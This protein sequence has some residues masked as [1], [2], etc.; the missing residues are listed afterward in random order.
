MPIQVEG[1][2][3][4]GDGSKLSTELATSIMPIFLSILKNKYA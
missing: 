2:T 1:V 4:L 3:I